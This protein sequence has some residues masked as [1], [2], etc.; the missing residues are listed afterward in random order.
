MYLLPFFYTA[1][2]HADSTALFDTKT[3][4]CADVTYALL[5]RTSQHTHQKKKKTVSCVVFDNGINVLIKQTYVFPYRVCT[6]ASFS[7]V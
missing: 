2:T 7:E 1:N 3:P 5:K 4:V 6:S